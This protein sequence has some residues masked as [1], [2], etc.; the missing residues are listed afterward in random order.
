MPTERQLVDSKW[1][2]KKKRYGKFWAHMVAWGYTQNTGLDFTKNY[3]SMIT[4]VTLR[5]T[6]LIWLINK[7]ASQ[8]IY[9]ETV[10]LF[11]V[12]EEEKQMKIPKVLVEVL[13]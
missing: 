3:S 6:L 8:T 5:A 13:E 1:I 11:P 4:Y 7:W 2:F 9:V 10:F 12:L